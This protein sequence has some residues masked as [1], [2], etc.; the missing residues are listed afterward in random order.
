MDEASNYQRH[1]SG[2]DCR[3]EWVLRPEWEEAHRERERERERD[4]QTNK[5]TDAERQTDR[6]TDRDI[7][8]PL[9]R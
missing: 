7:A 2:L 9:P 6:Q 4:R 8:A 1:S 5:Q 3:P